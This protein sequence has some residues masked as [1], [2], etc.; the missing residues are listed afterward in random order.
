MKNT[1]LEPNTLLDNYVI[2]SLKYTVYYTH[3]EHVTSAASECRYLA[4]FASNGTSKKGRKEKCVFNW[5]NR[6]AL[7]RS[8]RQHSHLWSGAQ[9]S[10]ITWLWVRGVFDLIRIRIES[11]AKNDCSV[12]MCTN[13]L[14]SGGDGTPQGLMHMD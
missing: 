9:D 7:T 14:H 12:L 2:N 6:K 4:H 1:E 5:H 13:E 8:N 10:K 3:I 11:T